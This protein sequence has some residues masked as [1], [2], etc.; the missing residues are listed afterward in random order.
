MNAYMLVYIRKSRVD[1]V[2]VDVKEDDVPSHISM[3]FLIYLLSGMTT[4]LNS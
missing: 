2:L 3:L 4:N 1:D